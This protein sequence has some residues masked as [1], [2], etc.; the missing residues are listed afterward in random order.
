MIMT[1][2]CQPSASHPANSALVLWTALVVGAVFFIAEHDWQASQ[3]D[4]FAAEADEMELMAA[5]GRLA[6]RLAFPVLAAW[7]LICFATTPRGNLKWHG[8]LPWLLVAYVLWCLAS[9][10]WCDDTSLTGRRLTVLGCCALGA[11]GLG[12]RLQLRELCQVGLLVSTF[13]VVMGLAVELGLQT[14][15]PW[16]PEH[17]FAGT[18]HPNTQALYCAVACLSSVAVLAQPG[19]SRRVLWLVFILAGALLLLTRSR[20]GCAALAAALIGYASLGFSWRAKTAGALGTLWTGCSA[21]LIAL[22]AGYDVLGHVGRMLLLGRDD[23]AD[24]LT[25]RVPLWGELLSYVQSRPLT[26][27]GYN[28]FWDPEH[29]YAVSS[30]LQWGIREAHNAYLDSTLSVGLI[31]TGLL[32]LAALLAALRA[33]IR[34]HATGNSGYGFLVALFVLGSANALLESGIILPM[35]VPFVTATGMA[36]LALHDCERG[37]R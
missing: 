6:R 33:A 10:V 16:R 23:Q 4:A 11:L 17:R 7:G 12:S 36:H 20:T 5:G 31:G 2:P 35:F 22:L 13:Y 32:V 24:S 9:L 1:G 27:Y 3:R 19:R 34:F 8:L 18:V 28:S 30:T 37:G 29:I 25:G 14:F 26:G 21:L 15:R